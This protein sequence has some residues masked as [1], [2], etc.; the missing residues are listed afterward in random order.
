MKKILLVSCVGLMTLG[1][2][3]ETKTPS[4]VR[5]EKTEIKAVV[6]DIDYSKREVT[7]KGPEGKTVKLTIGDKAKNFDQ[8][9]KGDVVLTTFYESVALSLA[10][11]GETPVG[12]AQGDTVRLADKGQ[13]ACRSC[14]NY[15]ANHRSSGRY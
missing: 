8:V 4:V 6:Q 7:L 13:K 14:F 15:K 11:K 9:K 2:F 10:K 5:S 12:Q 3:A 1:G